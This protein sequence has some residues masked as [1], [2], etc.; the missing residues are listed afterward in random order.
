MKRVI[1][2]IAAVALTGSAASACSSSSGTLST[3][4]YCQKIKN[5]KADAAKFDSVFS[6]NNPD[7]AQ[8][9]AAFETMSKMLKDLADT[10][11]ADIKPDVTKVVGATDKVIALLAKND[12]DMV[13]V[14]ANTADVAA[15]KVVLADTTVSVA[16]SHLD[17]Y[18]TTNCGIVPDTTA[19]AAA[20]TT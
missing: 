4:D 6:S 18:G 15:L 8:T 1:T 2:F 17:A 16:S 19:P 12:Y 14:S 3:A 10:A 9:K 20:T 5:Y 7:K 11:P 13:K